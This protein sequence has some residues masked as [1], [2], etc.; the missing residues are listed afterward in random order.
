M[1]KIIEVKQNNEIFDLLN[2][3]SPYLKSLESGEVDKLSLALKLTEKGI[4]IKYVVDEHPVSFAAFYCN[5]SIEKNAYLSLIA[6]LPEYTGQGIARTMLDK[7][8]EI[9]KAKGMETLRLQVRNDN[10]RAIRLY[11]NYGFK[12]MS[13]NDDNTFYMEKS[14]S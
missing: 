7:V 12:M 11:S 2:L 6:V 1:E 13:Y 4:V 14:I 3:F 8:V 9:S 10:E 5:D